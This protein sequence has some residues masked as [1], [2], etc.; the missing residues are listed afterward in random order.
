MIFDTK[1]VFEF[2]VGDISIGNDSG[3]EDAV[4]EMRISLWKKGMSILPPIPLLIYII[5]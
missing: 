2:Q 4:D 3:M 5:Y 1:K